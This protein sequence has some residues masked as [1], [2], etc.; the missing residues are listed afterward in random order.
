MV[1][2]ARY[3]ASSEPV[4]ATLATAA[5]ALSANANA[6]SSVGI[7]TALG[8]LIL[9]IAM[10]KGAFPKGMAMLGIVTGALGIPFEAFRDLIGPA[11]AL[12]GTL[13]PVWAIM[14]GIGLLRV[15]PRPCRS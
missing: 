7:L 12:Y 8:I 6:V 4:R 2:S 3:V 5:E 10:I 9:S 11:Y 15:R 1:L 14:V 13:L